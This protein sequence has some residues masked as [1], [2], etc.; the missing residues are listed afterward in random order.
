MRIFIVRASKARSDGKIDLLNLK[1]AG[2]FEVVCASI[3]NALWTSN[4]IRRDTKIH[5]ALEGPL[6][7]PKLITFEGASLSEE[8]S[9]E[10]TAIA[11][12][13]KDVFKGKHIAG[14]TLES[15]S[16]EALIKE[17]GLQEIDMFYM[18]PDGVDINA[19]LF[20]NNLIFILGDHRGIPIKTEDLLERRGAKKVALGPKMLFA[21][22][23]IP[24]IHNEL[25]RRELWKRP[26]TSFI[27]PQ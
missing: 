20:Q 15:K 10:E 14:V 3:A 21:S 17:Y 1:D 22:Q 4:E 5:V 19:I 12:T 8:I 27:P 23:C 25:D 26:N 24:I 9:Y 13:I 16:F 11:Q 7:P 6:T 2:H 18:H